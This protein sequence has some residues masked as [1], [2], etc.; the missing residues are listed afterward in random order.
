M[1]GPVLTTLDGG[2]RTVPAAS[3]DRLRSALGDGLCLP[4]D[5]GY[6]EARRLWNATI[7]RRPGLV[8]RCRDAAQVQAAMRFC[9][10]HDLLLAVRG[11]GH[12]I[13]GHAVCEGGV[14]IDLSP[15]R[16]VRV[17]PEHRTARVA[18]GCRLA[19]V[20][21]ATAPHGLAVP[22]GINST[23]GI[24]G[25]TLGGGYGWLSRAHGLTVDSLREAEIV[26]TDGRRLRTDRE[27]EP[28]LFWAI[29]GGSGNFGIVT[30]FVFDLH[31]VG[32]EVL[33]GPI[34]HPLA[35]APELLRRFR[36]LAAR[37]PDELTVWTVLRKA[38]PLPFLP[39]EWHGREVL[40]FAC[41]H[42]GDV[43]E[44]E[45]ALEPLRALGTPIADAVGPHPFAAWQQAF[46]PLL[47]EG[48]RN[49]WKSH[50]FDEL[51]DGL[52]DLLV[53]A[54]ERLPDEACEIFLAQLGGR[55]ARVD[56]AS[57]AFPHRRATFLVNV[58]ARWQDPA[59]DVACIAWAR[60]LFDRMAPFAAGGAY[61]NF[62][63]GDEAGRMR[64][65]FGASFDRLAALKAVWDPDNRLRVNPN[66]PPAAARA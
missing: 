28:D 8:A 51:D 18:A 64:Q 22:T 16:Q 47:A 66:I 9:A 7:D 39:P 54:T 5:A 50:N 42:A 29:R 34:V 48:A 57:T 60:E 25:L 43:A 33:S 58:H 12:N 2:R 61:V 26:T 45:R 3:L 23:T 37:M 40:I 36:E 46:D 53:E 14:Q 10:D 62:V 56:P 19:D 21:G 11:G 1:T 49:Y 52:I 55:A 63:P 65:V 27:R 30:E 41:C 35:A 17:D 24:A 31:P 59:D 4:G 6:E 20:D 38:P 15:M 44:G 13:A 32:P